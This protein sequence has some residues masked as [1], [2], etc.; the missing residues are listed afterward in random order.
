MTV[1]RG[2][3]RAW[4]LPVSM[5]AATVAGVNGL[6]PASAVPSP[7]AGSTTFDDGDHV[8]GGGKFFP[9]CSLH[10]HYKFRSLSDT[11]Y[12]LVIR[13]GK[14]VAKPIRNEGVLTATGASTLAE[15]ESDLI[16]AELFE[17]YGCPGCSDIGVSWVTTFD[18]ADR[19]RHAFDFSSPPEELVAA[20]AFIQDGISVL[21]SCTKSDNFRPRKLRCHALPRFR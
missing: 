14:D 21:T 10:C 9:E 5:L 8:V 12:Q 4:L 19:T 17:E 11:R 18:G 15:I 7:K 13:S 16:G 6:T 3:V 20:D 2:T 1:M